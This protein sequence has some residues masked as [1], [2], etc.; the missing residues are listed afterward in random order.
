MYDYAKVLQSLSGYDEVL[1]GR[2]V[3]FAYKR[4][5]IDVFWRFIDRVVGID[6]RSDVECIKDFLLLSLLPL[7]DPEMAHTLYE[8]YA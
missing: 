7:H 2:A 1:A 3:S 8:L 4:P 6:R 5:L